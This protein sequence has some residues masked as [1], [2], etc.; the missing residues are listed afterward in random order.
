MFLPERRYCTMEFVRAVMNGRKRYFKNE[1]VRK[2][3]V[4]RYKQL[5]YQ[6]VIEYCNEKPNIMRYLP[7]QRLDG[8]PTCDREFLFTILNT[9]EPEYFPS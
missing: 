2:V 4:P 5:T 6:R 3:R 1:E 9:I 8:E 7:N